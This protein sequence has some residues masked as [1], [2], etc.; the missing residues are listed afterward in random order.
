[1]NMKKSLILALGLIASSIAQANVITFDDLPKVEFGDVISNG[2]KGFNWDW[3]SY[4]DKYALP[5]TGFET[6]VVSGNY[7]AYNDFAATATTSGSWFD[8]NGAYL[9][10]AWNNGLNIEVTGFVGGTQAYSKT[11]VVNT[12]NA[13]WFDFNFFGIDALSFRSFGGEK[14]QLL[15]GEGEHFILDDFTYNEP[16]GTNVPEPSGLVLLGIGIA[17]LGLLSH[18]KINTKPSERPD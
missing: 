9:T 3:F 2:Y 13:Q 16:R 18:T 6:G 8:F 5:N 15:D 11:V 7:A 12:L 4:I 1:M 14:N 17:L 10:G